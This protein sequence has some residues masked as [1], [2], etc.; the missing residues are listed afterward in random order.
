MDAFF[1]SA[2]LTVVAVCALLVAE[3]RDHGLSRAI[4]KP[5][6][7]SGFIAAALAR[8]ALDS[9]HGQA[10]LA[11]FALCWLGDVLLLSRGQ[12]GFLAGL[13]AF[14]LGHLGFVAAF[15]LRGVETRMSAMA[16][17]LLL[18]LAVYVVRWLLPKAPARLRVPIVLYVVVITAMVA[19]A[20]GT[21]PVVGIGAI[22]VGAVAFYL[23]DLCVAVDRFVSPGFRIRRWGL[24]LYYGAQLV[25]AW[26]A[27]VG[28]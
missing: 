8:G 21:Y 15:V 18:V 5:L 14:L 3:W 1:T 19:L 16:A 12:A 20:I 23:S 25:L 13:V 24:P 22:V 7:S 4:I 28:L 9:D 2:L 11:A 26:T 27:G 17:V 10:L 6:A